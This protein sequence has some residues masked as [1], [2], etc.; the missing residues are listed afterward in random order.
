M[1]NIS[2]L[3]LTFVICLVFNA[4]NKDEEI[5]F[6]LSAKLN[7]SADTLLFDTVF[8]SIGSTS[9]RL[10]IKNTNGKAINLNSIKLAGGNTSSFSLNINGNA[11]N[12]ETNLKINGKDS[13]SLFVKVNINPTLVNLPF[14]VQDSILFDYNGQK[15]KIALI[16]YGQNA[17]FINNLTINNNA[18]WSS[19][20]P[21]IVYKSVTVNKDATLTLPAGAKILFHNNATMH[22]KGTLIANGTKT[23]SIVFASDR[24]EKVYANESGQW[25]G[26][27]FYPESKNNTINYAIVKNGVV[28]LT[29]DSLSINQLPKLL[30]T[31]S[32]IKNMEV[33]G[34]L[35]YKTDVVALNNLFYNC[36]QYLFYIAGGGQYNLKQ[37]TFVGHAA[38]FVRKT[39]LL[40][41]SDDVN[42]T[43]ASNLKL[44]M[45]NNI[46]WGMLN[47]EL[48]IAKKNN[49]TTLI[50]DLQNNLLKSTLS[51]LKNTSNLLNLDPQFINPYAENF[52]LGTNSP[53]KAKGLNL[54]ND[55]Y[56]NNFLNKDL[57]GKT[58][59]F[60]SALGCYE[61]N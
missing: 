34:F 35:G 9:R 40:Y 21:Y 46:V 24:L 43:S 16:A 14:I 15:Q 55:A 41:F 26:L 36:G 7:F 19:P 23:D 38:N 45:Y 22:I 59:I 37:N 39:P 4:C 42:N 25:N 57:K 27:H 29:A 12:E 61:I 2:L 28:G 31:N 1:K 60:P 32:I 20:L 3:I 47:D 10:K 5:T 18:T 56:F 51:T 49:L 8:T 13:I 52:K 48:L 30:L 11:S 53:A 17:I 33:V 54:S 6:D 58:R 50:T 44:V